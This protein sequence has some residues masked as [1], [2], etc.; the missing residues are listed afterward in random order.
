MMDGYAPESACA[1]FRVQLAQWMDP[2]CPRK[3]PASRMTR[4][5]NKVTISTRLVHRSMSRQVVQRNSSIN[6]RRYPDRSNSEDQ[7]LK[8]A[9]ALL[10]GLGIGIFVGAAL[11]SY[12]ERIATELRRDATH[13]ALEACP[14]QSKPIQ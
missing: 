10:N 3:L 5:P 1:V 13:Q 12:G 4:M 8:I 7:V 11:G 14:D 6:G 9:F 2:Y